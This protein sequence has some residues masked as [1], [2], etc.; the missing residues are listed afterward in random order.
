LVVKDKKLKKERKTRKPPPPPPEKGASL[1]QGLLLRR[2]LY[3]F[4]ARKLAA[5]NFVFRYLYISQVRTVK[6]ADLIVVHMV[7]GTLCF[8]I[9]LQFRNDYAALAP[10]HC[11]Q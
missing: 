1:G 6:V 3:A 7:A 4:Q 9:R 2:I 11:F 10:Q 5:N 8:D